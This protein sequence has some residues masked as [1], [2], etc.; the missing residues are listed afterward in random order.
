VL[1]RFSFFRSTRKLSPPEFPDMSPALA[2]Q[3]RE[4]D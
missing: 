1:D 4:G 2:A 3:E